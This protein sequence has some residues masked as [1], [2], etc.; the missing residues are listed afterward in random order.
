MGP[1]PPSFEAHSGGMR[2]H[3]PDGKW[4][5]VPFGEFWGKNWYDVAAQFYCKANT[6]APPGPTPS[7]TPSPTP[8]N[9]LLDDFARNGVNNPDDPNNPPPFPP[10]KS[11]D[12]H[13]REYRRGKW[14]FVPKSSRSP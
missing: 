12:T 9:D 1:L 7:P 4:I 10:G 2:I 8:I 6:G 3:F 14:I 11:P 13:H 5:D